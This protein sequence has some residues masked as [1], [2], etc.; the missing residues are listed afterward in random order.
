M[1]TR[2]KGGEERKRVIRGGREGVEGVGG[3]CL[4]RAMMSPM[5]ESWERMD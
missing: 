2:M 1:G 4:P 3:R 5:A